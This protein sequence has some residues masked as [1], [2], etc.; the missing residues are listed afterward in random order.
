MYQ[1]RSSLPSA[2]G[3]S[4]GV[5]RR[6]PPHAQ[7]AMAQLS[8]IESLEP[9]S[10]AL[11]GQS[12]HTTP[13]D[14]SATAS[15]TAS[16]HLDGPTPPPRRAC[17][18]GCAHRARAPG[19]RCCRFRPT[20]CPRRDDP[21]AR[22]WSVRS[23]ALNGAASPAS[24]PTEHAAASG[25]AC[26]HGTRPVQLHHNPFDYNRI[27]TVLRTNVVLPP[28]IAYLFP[29]CAAGKARWQLGE[30][31]RA[32][33]GPQG[34]LA[35]CPSSYFKRWGLVA[36]SMARLGSVLLLGLL[37]FP[38][39]VERESSRVPELSRDVHDACYILI[40]CRA[41]DRTR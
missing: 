4:L 28:C 41:I 17:C 9:H 14:H 2:D 18:S 35:S 16:A 26:V 22:G 25:S 7:A 19:G 10:A 32:Q 30:L 20:G 37:L 34:G 31:V 5:P 27:P 11:I 39:S 40:V 24:R 23:G 8:K 38:S 3:H 15:A 13:S 33:H 1:P 36:A 29:H 21:I 12:D 6:G